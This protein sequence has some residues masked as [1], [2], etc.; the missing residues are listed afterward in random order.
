MT[1]IEAYKE[2]LKVLKKHDDLLEDDY[3]IDIKGELINRISLQEISAE[4]GIELKNKNY[5][6]DWC[7]LAEYQY[8][9]L[10]GEDHN[11]TISWSDDG[12]QPE[13]ERL[14]I[15]IFPTGA[16]IF[17]DS[18]PTNT[19]KMFWDELKSYGPKYTDTANHN[20]YFTA[21]NA[22]HV[23]KEFNSV[24]NK[25]KSLVGE[26]LRV[27]KIEALKDQLAKL[28]STQTA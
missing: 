3:K 10:Y 12:S 23:H 8:I 1:K 22:K 26:E 11:R 7:K 18:Y 13:N 5:N 28:Q 15:I 21:E 25:H 24:F 14:Y 17:G 6:S 2:I 27:K 19:F 9:G 4:F 20:M 16:Y